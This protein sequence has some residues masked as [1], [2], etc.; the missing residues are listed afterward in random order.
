MILIVLEL[1][2]KP[3][4]VTLARISEESRLADWLRGDPRIG[5]LLAAAVRIVRHPEQGAPEGMTS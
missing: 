3:R 5:E 2:E 4:I 1:E